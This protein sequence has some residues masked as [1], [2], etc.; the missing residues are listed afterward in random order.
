MIHGYFFLNFFKLTNYLMPNNDIFSSP[1]ND[2][3]PILIIILIL[4]LKL[5]CYSSASAIV[6]DC[7]TFIVRFNSPTVFLCVLYPSY[8]WIRRITRLKNTKVKS[9]PFLL[10]FFLAS[11]I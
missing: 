5:Q 10:I 8:Y 4:I 2:V 3:G 11:N 9:F 7:C 6:P 1:I